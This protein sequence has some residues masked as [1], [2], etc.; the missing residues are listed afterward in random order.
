MPKR[1]AAT[2]LYAG[3]A[4]RKTSRLLA[5]IMRMGVHGIGKTFGDIV[6]RLDNIEKR[7]SDFG[8][9]LSNIV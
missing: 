3:N 2:R 8:N 6:E 5:R 1:R 7:P 9:D 4:L